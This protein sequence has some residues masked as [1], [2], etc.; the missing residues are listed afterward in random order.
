MKHFGG[1]DLSSYDD[2]KGDAASIYDRLAAGSM[3]CDGP[4]S[5]ENVQRLKEWMDG[6]ANP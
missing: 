4:W 2:V 6:G 1:F 5:D 3:P